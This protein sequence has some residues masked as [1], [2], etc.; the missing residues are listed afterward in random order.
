M[1]EDV[2]IP[3]NLEPLVSLYRTE[4]DKP[5]RTPSPARSE[6]EDPE[7]EDPEFADPDE[8]VDE[9]DVEAPALAPRRGNAQQTATLGKV[10]PS[11]RN[12]YRRLA[13][14]VPNLIRTASAEEPDE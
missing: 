14:L 10:D 4:R 9:P 1:G 7:P 2:D 11:L 8:E 12:P 6:P 13:A 5:R 3:P